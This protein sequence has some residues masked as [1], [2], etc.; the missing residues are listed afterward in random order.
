M[1]SANLKYYNI[2]LESTITT[3]VKLLLEELWQHMFDTYLPEKPQKNNP[4]DLFTRGIS[5]SHFKNSDLWF[6]GPT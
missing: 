6:N 4:A 5:T 1:S 2:R 3:G